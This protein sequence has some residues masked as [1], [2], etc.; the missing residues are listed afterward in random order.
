MTQDARL[1]L[2]PELPRQKQH[3]KIEDSVH[4]QIW[5]KFKEKLV[6]F[7]LWTNLW[8]VLS[9]TSQSRS[10]TPRTFCNEMV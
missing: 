9:D 1:K 10:E 5:L 3:S 6:K 4:K 8:M 7:Y 2:N